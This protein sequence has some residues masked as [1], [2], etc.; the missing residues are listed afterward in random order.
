MRTETKIYP[1]N[2]EW[3]FSFTAPKS[4]EKIQ[5][6]ATVPGNVELELMRIGLVEDCHPNDCAFTMQKFEPVDD[7]T[8]SCTL[9]APSPLQIGRNSWYLRALTPLPRST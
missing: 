6:T 9:G 8:Y 4:G 2:G 5:T 7:W 1:L 3:S